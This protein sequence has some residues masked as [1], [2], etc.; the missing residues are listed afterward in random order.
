[1][2]EPHDRLNGRSLL[3]AGLVIAVGALLGVAGFAVDQ[4]RATWRPVIAKTASGWRV[5]QPHLGVD[6]PALAAGR[7]VWTAGAYTVMA[8]L[9]SGRSKLLGVAGSSHSVFPPAI[10]SRFAV[11]QDVTGTTSQQSRVFSYDVRV[12][13]RQHRPTGPLDSEPIVCGTTA[14]W[15]SPAAGGTDAVV[16]CD[17][18]T[19]RRR[20]LAQVPHFVGWLTADSDY[21]VW[22]RQPAPQAQFTLTVFELAT[23][24][25]HDLVLPGQSPGSHFGE[26]VLAGGVLVWLR[27]PPSGPST[28]EAYDLRSAAASLVATGAGLTTPAFDGAT[29]VW[30]QQDGPDAVVYGRRPAGGDLLTIATVRAPVASVMVSGRTVAWWAGVGADS[31]V[32]TARLPG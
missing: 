19:G 5:S 29:V 14:Y 2:D 3:T 27:M 6:Q 13:R 15:A 25:A 32:A 1:M 9:D 20:V 18:E 8:D 16:A 10:S 12:G 21:V 28:I 24:I 23:G 7:L 30:A 31:W 17:L 4:E 26:P 11:W 22:A